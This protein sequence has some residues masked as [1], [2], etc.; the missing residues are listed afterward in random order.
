MLWIGT[1][2]GYVDSPHQ[3]LSPHPTRPVYQHFFGPNVPLPVN[4]GAS[5]N[6][7]A[8][9]SNLDIASSNAGGQFSQQGSTDSSQVCTMLV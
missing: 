1:P 4:E 5:N 9:N 2:A 7:S 6:N 3:H 8:D